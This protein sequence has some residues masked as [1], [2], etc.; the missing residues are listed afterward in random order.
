VNLGLFYNLTTNKEVCM[1]LCFSLIISVLCS[2][3]FIAGCSKDNN[4][5]AEVAPLD[6]LT[7]T[8]S[9]KGWE[10]YSWPEGNSWKFSFLVGT[11]RLKTLLEVTSSN[12][13]EVL[14]RVTGV[15]SAKMVLNK[16]PSGEDIMLIGQGWL[17]TV[18]RGQYGN[19]QLP[20]QAVID[21]LKSFSTQKNI[22]FT[23]A[24]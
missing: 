23:V 9:M 18:W 19:L 2:T 12:G 8:P 14:I 15:D 13:A 16:F 24:N 6:N 21:E 20:P 5:L 1:K 22:T 11:N 4:E 10:L 3:A 7:A 17:Q